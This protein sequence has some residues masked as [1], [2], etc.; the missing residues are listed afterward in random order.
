MNELVEY[1]IKRKKNSCGASCRNYS[2]YVLIFVL[3]SLS[4][5]IADERRRK[6]PTFII[7]RLLTE[8]S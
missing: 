5:A 2:F 4:I 7:L 8:F 6:A 3:A 1:D